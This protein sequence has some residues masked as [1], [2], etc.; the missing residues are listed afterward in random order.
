MSNSNDVVTQASVQTAY[1]VQN[2]PQS[3]QSPGII[4]QQQPAPQVIYTTPAVAPR[5]IVY[6]EYREVGPKP[7]DYC[8]LSWLTCLCCFWPVGLCAI[9]FSCQTNDKYASGDLKGAEK[10]SETTKKLCLLALVIGIVLYIF[11]IWMSE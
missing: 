1:P 11:S 2:Y 4:V 3:S 9:F 7:K 5:V 10:A 8:I 6:E